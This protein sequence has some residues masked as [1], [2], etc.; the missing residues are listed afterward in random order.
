MVINM[1]FHAVDFPHPLR[2]YH[3]VGKT[4]RHNTALGKKIEPVTVAE[5]EV[6]VM[7]CHECRDSEALN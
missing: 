5:R 1:C 6:Q 4:S 7:K 2:C 3:F